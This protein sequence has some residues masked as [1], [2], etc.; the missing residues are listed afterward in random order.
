MNRGGGR[1]RFALV[2][3]GILILPAPATAQDCIRAYEAAATPYWR[4]AHDIQTF[5]A[6]FNDYD[7]LCSQ[8]FPDA[9]NALQ[10]R[11]D[12]LRAQVQA[13]FERTPKII[14][15]LFAHTLPHTV[16]KDCSGD[17]TA[18][19]IVENNLLN[20]LKARADHTDKRLKRSAANV[21]NPD[22]SLKLCRDLGTHAPRI[23]KTLGPGLSNPLLE[24]TALHAQAT[25]TADAR[26]RAALKHWRAALKQIEQEKGT[27]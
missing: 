7:R 18:R 1:V 23:E 26:H 11:A 13:D 27:E 9:V 6:M 3:A 16:D 4:I 17:E 12:R 24:M 20:T 21:H 2:V 25:R 10:P 22:E 5:R 15:H 14:R 8:H 19:K